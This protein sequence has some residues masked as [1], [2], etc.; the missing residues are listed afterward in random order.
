MSRESYEQ[1]LDATCAELG[2]EEVRVL[3]HLAARLLEGQRQYG[4]LALATDTRDWRRERAE[5]A[6]DI[7]MYSA[8]EV[9]RAEVAAESAPNGEGAPTVKRSVVGRGEGT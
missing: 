5:E 2:D 4:R 6:A 8:F 1:L 9:V 3:A 7:L